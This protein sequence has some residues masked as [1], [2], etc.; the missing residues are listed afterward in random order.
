M[1]RYNLLKKHLTFD[2]ANIAF[3]EAEVQFQDFFNWW[4]TEEFINL[5]E[6]QL[7][8]VENIQVQNNFT[9]ITRQNDFEYIKIKNNF[10]GSR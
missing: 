8:P 9:P 2:E 6:A 1:E 10:N 7:Q 5:P 4:I 3:G